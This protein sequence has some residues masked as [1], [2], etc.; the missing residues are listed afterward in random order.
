MRDL[1]AWLHSV[2]GVVPPPKDWDALERRVESRTTSTRVGA[3]PST[4][5]RL[6]AIVVGGAISLAAFAF[7]WTAWRSPAS[8][9]DATITAA[10]YPD[11]PQDGY[12]FVFPYSPDADG[13][14]S[15]GVTVVA[16]TNLPDGT[17]VMIL[18]SSGGGCCQAV[19]G[20]KIVVQVS[21]AACS[22]QPPV[23]QAGGQATITLLAAP[24]VG[25]RIFGVPLG[26]APPGQPKIVLQTLGTHFEN[27]SGKQVVVEGNNRVLEATMSFEWP[28]PLC[29]GG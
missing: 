8:N 9:D 14:G 27:L 13:D 26:S 15:G 7:A 6:M 3:S 5:S 29:F 10:S 25:E 11:P 24:D 4:A 18:T 20:G 22:P 16:R 23:S 21:P 17:L 1:K 28:A 19:S 2:D 12:W